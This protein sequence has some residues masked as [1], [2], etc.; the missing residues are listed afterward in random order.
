MAVSLQIAIEA[1]YQNDYLTRECQMAIAAQ[2]YVPPLVCWLAAD[3]GSAPLT[4]WH[5]PTYK[6][7]HLMT[8]MLCRLRCLAFSAKALL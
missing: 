3:I 5:A 1:M 7:T 8:P 4:G 6:I 2:G